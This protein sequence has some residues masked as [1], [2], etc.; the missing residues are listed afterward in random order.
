MLVCVSGHNQVNVSNR[1]LQTFRPPLPTSRLHGLESVFVFLSNSVE[2]HQKTGRAINAFSLI[3][4]AR[5]A[6]HVLMTNVMIAKTPP[7]NIVNIF[8]TC[9]PKVRHLHLFSLSSKQ[10]A[11]L[12]FSLCVL[13]NIY[14][15]HSW[16]RFL[17]QALLRRTY[18]SVYHLRDKQIALMCIYACKQID[19]STHV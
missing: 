2:S 11:D 4:T 6:K 10:C 14:F 17:E 16:N 5:Q 3:S 18:V 13:N 15:H 19:M 1:C 9:S 12:S 7:F 8:L